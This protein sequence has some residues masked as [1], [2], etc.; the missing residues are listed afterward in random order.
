M[1]NIPRLT[2]IDTYAL[3]EFPEKIS[4]RELPYP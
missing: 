1:F 2:N 4:L 3:I